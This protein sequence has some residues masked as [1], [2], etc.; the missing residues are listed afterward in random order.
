MGNDATAGT[1][2]WGRDVGEIGATAVRGG[3]YTFDGLKPNTHY[4]AVLYSP[5]L[6]YGNLRP[7]VMVC[8]RTARDPNNPWGGTATGCFAPYTP[9]IDGTLRPANYTACKT[10]RDACNNN[11]DTTW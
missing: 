7:L 2:V 10:A 11:S 8:F 3:P 5:Y 9:T 6:G 1:V 4:V